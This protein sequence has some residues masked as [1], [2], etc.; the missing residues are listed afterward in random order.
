MIREVFLLDYRDNDAFGYLRDS[1]EHTALHLGRLGVGARSRPVLHRPRAAG[2]VLA[3]AQLADELGGVDTLTTS[4]L[5]PH[6]P[7]PFTNGRQLKACLIGEIAA[8]M[9]ASDMPRQPH[10]QHLVIAGG[11][12]HNEFLS[13]YPSGSALDYM[14]YSPT[15]NIMAKYVIES[16]RLDAIRD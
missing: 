1:V 2:T 7:R 3:A 8:S 9:A 4:F 10:E 12:L 14:K 16:V 15:E 11:K 13:H 6:W 5:K